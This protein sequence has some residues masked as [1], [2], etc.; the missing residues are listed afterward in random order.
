MMG[1]SKL[2][3]ASCLFAFAMA[4]TSH[5][6]NHDNLYITSGFSCDDCVSGVVM[7]GADVVNYFNVS[8]G[9]V[10]QTLGSPSYAVEYQGYKYHFLNADNAATFINNPDPFVP[11][12]GGFCAWGV[13]REGTNGNPSPAAEPGWPWTATHLGPPCGPHD[14]WSIVDGTLY[15]SIASQYMA[16]FLALG[17]IGPR[18]GNIRW[19]NWFG[20]VSSGPLNSG[21]YAGPSSQTCEDTGLPSSDIKNRTHGSGPRPIPPVP[22]SPPS[23]TPPSPGPSPPPSTLPPACRQA[24]VRDCPGLN[25]TKSEACL[26]CIDNHPDVVAMC[27]SV[28]KHQVVEEYCGA[29]TNATALDAPEFECN[30]CLPGVVM[31]GADVVNYFNVP[32]GS[33]VK[34]LG[35]PNHSIEYEGYK[36]YFLNAENAVTFSNSPDQFIPAY[37]GFC[38]RGIAREGI[39][40]NPS[41][42]AE[43]G[44]PWEPTHMGPPCGPHDGWSIINNKLYCAIG[45]QVIQ[46]FIELG[47][48]GISDANTR[49]STWFGNPTS[50]YINDQCFAGETMHACLN[51]GMPFH[52]RTHNKYNS[53]E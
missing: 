3:I 26:K 18:D 9:T 51:T 45:A 28:P 33:V 2:V 47:P 34:N 24:L 1:L 21:C 46:Q 52:N 35:S 11:A 6:V 23:P 19:T 29:K 22:P 50:G 16:K 13:A 43:P 42:A 48:Q 49:W 31:G 53:T 7:G 36:F 40:G 14:G 27:R 37:G 38:A 25:G 4:E 10:V 17:S 32:N 44:W 5:K 30:D 15:C 8:K 39:N 20:N 12:Y 41:K